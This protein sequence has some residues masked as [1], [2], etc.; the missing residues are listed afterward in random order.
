MFETYIT[1]K[2]CKQISTTATT[3]NG[4]QQT[5]RNEENEKKNV[6]EIHEIHYK[7]EN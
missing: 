5:N 2:A 4:D 7:C 6:D 1:I 3:I